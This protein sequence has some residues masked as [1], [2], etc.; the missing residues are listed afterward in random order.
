MPVAMAAALVCGGLIGAVNGALVAGLRL[1]SIVVTLSTLV[2][3]RESLRYFREGEFVR[4]LPPGFQWFGLTQA[5]GQWTVV[6]IALVS[7]A[8]AAWGLA[9]LA[10][11]RA[12]YAVGS[13]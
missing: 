5:E 9:H 6:A 2:A 13:N 10:G 12:I 3:V 1:P 11:G 4:N 7:V 8:L